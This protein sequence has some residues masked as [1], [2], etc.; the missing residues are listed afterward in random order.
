MK[1]FK[2]MLAVIMVV[3]MYACNSSETAAPAGDAATTDSTQVEG[4]HTEEDH[5]GHNH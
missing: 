2:L 3:G 5:S 4:E 1:K